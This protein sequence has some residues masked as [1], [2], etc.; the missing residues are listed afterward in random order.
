[1]DKIKVYLQSPWKF[2]DSPYY[3]Y[4]RQNPPKDV[5]YVNA[6]D[7][8][9]IQSGKKLRFRNKVK[10]FLKKALKLLSG[11]PN[12]HLS[13]TNKEY[14]LIHCAH[15]LSLNKKPWVCDIEY[16]NQF[17]ASGHIG[18]KNRILKILKKDS[19]KK[20]LAW[21]KWSEDGIL[22]EFPEIQSKVEIVYPGIPVQSFNKKKSERIT[23]LFSSR[24]FIFKGGLHALE[25]IDRLTKRYGNVY[26]IVI[27]DVPEEIK[28]NYSGNNK[29]DF[30]GFVSQDKLFKEI[31]PKAD[32]FVYPSYTD[33]FGFGLTEAL[34]FGLP[35]V[36]VGGLSRREIISDNETGFVIDEPNNFDIMHL[37]NLEDYSDIIKQIEQKTEIL[38]NNEKLRKIMSKNCLKE[39]SEGKFSINQRN[40]KLKQIYG[41]AIK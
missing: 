10:H 21:T 7:F 5:E 39:I 19:C 9:L 13:K 15:C 33:T 26:G 36:T 1:M 32:I 11:L 34:S 4:L 3:M 17:W 40:E 22:K 25:V 8:G 23:L 18:S 38:I 6:N 12:A 14:N 2:S 30:L 41:D 35:V 31:Y 29:I 16:V 27:S 24:R 37:N 20:I 28:K